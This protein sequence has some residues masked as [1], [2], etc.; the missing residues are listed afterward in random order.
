MPKPPPSLSPVGAMYH[1][2]PYHAIPCHTMPHQPIALEHQYIGTVIPEFLV[3]QQPCNITNRGLA[4]LD[5]GIP[6][7]GKLLWGLIFVVF[8]DDCLTVKIKPAK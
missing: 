5:S 2:M 8:V 3:K 4:W 7:S 6:Y 1:T